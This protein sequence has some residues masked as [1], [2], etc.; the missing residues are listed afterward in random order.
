MRCWRV[1]YI[2][3]MWFLF[4]PCGLFA[5]IA[6]PEYSHT[7]GFYDTTF[8]LELTSE[9]ANSAILYTTDGTQPSPKNGI[10][11]TQPVPVSQTTS[12]R[13]ITL[14]NDTTYSEIRTHTFVFLENVIQQDNSGVPETQH[15]QDHVYW[16]EEFDMNDVS[17][18]EEEIKEALLDIPTMSIVANYDSLFGIVGILRGQNL[19][20]GSG[21]K[22]GDPNE[23]GWKEEIQ[24]SVELIYPEN[25][26]F[27]QYDDWQKDAGISVQGGGGRWDNGYYD[28]KQSFTLK[29]MGELG[30]NLEHD[31][32]TAAPYNREKSPGEWDKVI[33]R[34][35]HNKSWGADW[36]RANTV[37]TRDQFGRDLQLLMSGWGSMGTFVHLYIN[38][39]YWGLYNP[40]ERMDDDAM[41][42]YFGG[43]GED[44][45]YG[46]GK[47]GDRSGSD[48][49]YDHLNSTYW[50]NKQLSD[51]AG[52][53][54]IDEYVDMCLLHSYA[55]PGDG[56]QYYY[57]N[58]NIPPGPAYFTA[59]D[60]EDSFEG[61]SRR[62][63]PP[64]SIEDLDKAGRDEF[65]TY[66]QVRGN[67]DF[68]MK[69]ADRAYKHAFNQGVLS[70]EQATAVWDSLN[71]FIEKAILCEIARWGD[72][73]GFLYDF[74]HWHKEWQDVN[75]DL[76]GR[77]L[78]LV[79][80]LRAERMYPSIQP[81]LIKSGGQPINSN[82]LLRSA[83]TV[84]LLL[85][86]EFD[87][88]T[89]YYTVDGTDPRQWDLTGD[90]S[91]S[92]IQVNGES[93]IVT[94]EKPT[95]VKARSRDGEEWSPLRE[96][97]VI[98]GASSDVVINEIN[99]NSSPDVDTEDWVEIYN[100]SGQ[101]IY[102]TG[103][104]L[105]DSDVNNI[106]RFPPGMQ[107][108]SDDYLIICNDTTD[109]KS[110]FPEVTNFIGEMDFKLSNGGDAVRLY[111]NDT[112][113]DSVSYSDTQPWPTKDIGYGATLE[114]M[115]P[116]FDNGRP[117]SWTSS[118]KFGTPGGL[119]SG[120]IT[121]YEED[122]PNSLPGRYEFYQNYPNPFNSNTVFKYSLSAPGDVD[123]RIYNILGKEVTLLVDEKKPAGSYNQRFDATDL[124]SGVYFAR[125]R[126]DSFSKTI[127][128]LLI[129]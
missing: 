121:R 50:G 75:D 123:L 67:I 115:N 129:N 103:W 2:L 94:I 90:A 93:E 66:F 7:R 116:E 65:Q 59:W 119:N 124:P 73:R 19:R 100:N 81:P 127:K 69:F 43:D 111:S 120:T 70:E 91:P 62:T 15:S 87:S 10:Q 102:L 34:A 95:V 52:Y 21:G 47:D 88:G 53:L 36:D 89:I 20:E 97:T 48:D 12:V 105:T 16:T 3:Y 117:E 96:L 45:Y 118:K 101:D 24:C 112:L 86:R 35:G 51:L 28:H 56:P 9:E 27:G 23:P 58:R 13:A 57:G 64:V 80:A 125:I 78:K 98:P 76:V 83:T 85:E 63:G 72:E 106:F 113:I 109:F 44:Y 5:Q 41:A 42:I 55:N 99:Y 60:I 108:Q 110:H 14:V 92:S 1:K 4:L 126:V 22:S 74:D 31:I 128:M 18:T 77:D 71:R 104:V 17:Q 49:R 30:G 54:A 8:D 38:G 40:C 33:L 68:R 26:K 11:Y 6:Q 122:T 107:L 46:K 29:F 84:G 82:I 39:K 32:F 37:Y 25:T 114:L 79:N 61:G